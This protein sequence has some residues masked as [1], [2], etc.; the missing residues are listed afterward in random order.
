MTVLCQDIGDTSGVLVVTLLPSR[1]VVERL[2]LP[3]RRMSLLIPVSVSRSR[4]GRRM[5]RAGR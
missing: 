1:E 2:D 4:S 3:V 5:R